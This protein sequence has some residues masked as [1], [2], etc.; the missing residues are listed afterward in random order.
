MRLRGR[1]DI[2]RVFHNVL[3]LAKAIQNELHTLVDVDTV[4]SAQ[5]SDRITI[6]LGGGKVKFESRDEEKRVGLCKWVFLSARRIKSTSSRLFFCVI[7]VFPLVFLGVIASMADW[8]TTRR[9][10]SIAVSM[11]LTIFLVAI[12]V[13]RRWRP[14]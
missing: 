6:D 4:T 11:C 7:C 3:H 1:K 2:P 5:L 12:E 14:S 8:E 9:V 13:T 10:I